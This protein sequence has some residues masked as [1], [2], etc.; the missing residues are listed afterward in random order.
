M[1]LS[2]QHFVTL[3]MDHQSGVERVFIPRPFELASLTW[4]GLSSMLRCAM[5]VLHKSSGK[6]WIQKV[7]MSLYLPVSPSPPPLSLSLT[8]PISPLSL[9]PT[10]TLPLSPPSL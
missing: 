1:H 4:P 8:L 9:S 10:L 5:L 7:S 3:Q 6:P 2:T